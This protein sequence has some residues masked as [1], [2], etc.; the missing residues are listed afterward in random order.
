MMEP[1]SFKKHERR[2]VVPLLLLRWSVEYGG[3]EQLPR[4]LLTWSAR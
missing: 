4:L 1:A 3:E 2:K